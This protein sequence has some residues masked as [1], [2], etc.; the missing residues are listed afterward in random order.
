MPYVRHGPKDG[1]LAMLSVKL[2]Q[3][4]TPTQDTVQLRMYCIVLSFMVIHR[5]LMS[6]RLSCIP[7]RPL[8]VEVRSVE[9]S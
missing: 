5:C 3:M 8:H 1:Q 7:M 2:F 6:V 4:T 9:L